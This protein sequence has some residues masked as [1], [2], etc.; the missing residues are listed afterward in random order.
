[1]ESERDWMAVSE[2]VVQILGEPCLLSLLR[3][4]TWN[5]T[6]VEGCSLSTPVLALWCEILRRRFYLASPSGFVVRLQ[7]LVVVVELG[8][9]LLLLLLQGHQV[10]MFLLQLPLQSFRLTLFLQLLA[11]VFLSRE[12]QYCQA[13]RLNKASHEA[14]AKQQ[15]F[16]HWN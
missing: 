2:T 5:V 15:G 4:S 1:M 6:T 3:S 13:A 11:L 14:S 8:L 7:I 9:L 10:G 12:I 16:S